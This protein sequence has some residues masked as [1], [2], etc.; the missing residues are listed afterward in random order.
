MRACPHMTRQAARTAAVAPA[1]AAGMCRSL[2]TPCCT[3]VRRGG[4]QQVQHA[5]AELLETLRA[6]FLD[7][8]ALGMYEPRHRL[9]ALPSG[10]DTAAVCGDTRFW[11]KS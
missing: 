9:V 8:Y 7:R 1:A 11:E 2:G 6:C 5:L 10:Q 4:I 3:C